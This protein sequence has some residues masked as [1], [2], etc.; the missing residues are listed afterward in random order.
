MN[1]FEIWLVVLYWCQKPSG[2]PR[3]SRARGQRQFGR[4]HPVRLGAPTQSVWAP[5]PSPF[6]ATQMRRMSWE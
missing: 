6:V 1:H 5:P 4:P 2:V 3:V